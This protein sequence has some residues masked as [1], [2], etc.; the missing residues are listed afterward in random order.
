MQNLR[1]QRL[2]LGPSSEVYLYVNQ[3]QFIYICLIDFTQ[4]FSERAEMV[5][6]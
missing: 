2:G 6:H 1:F 3:D 4:P 5:Y